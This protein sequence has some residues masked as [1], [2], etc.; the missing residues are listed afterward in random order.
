MYEVSVKNEFTAT[1][2]ILLPDGSFE[3]PHEHNWVFTAYFRSNE[4]DQPQGIV[5]DFVEV[6]RAMKSIAAELNGTNLDSMDEFDKKGA[7]AERVAEVLAN[8]LQARLNGGYKLY[9]VT[10]TETRDCCASYYMKT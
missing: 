4:L 10:V 8:R 6:A 2:A 9:K 3:K 1:H 7:S 5:I